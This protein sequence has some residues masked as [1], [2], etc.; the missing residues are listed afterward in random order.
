VRAAGGGQTQCDLLDDGSDAAEAG[1]ALGGGHDGCACFDDNALARAQ[2]SAASD[3][4]WLHAAWACGLVE[5]L[6]FDGG[7]LTIVASIGWAC[8]TAGKEKEEE[9]EHGVAGMPSRHAHGNQF[10]RGGYP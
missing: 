4:V 10:F 1:V 2:V 5:R 9:E 6:R 8:N 3:H 7:K